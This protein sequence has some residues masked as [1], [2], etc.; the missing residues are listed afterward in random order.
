M[1]GGWRWMLGPLEE[2]QMNFQLILDYIRIN[3]KSFSFRLCNGWKRIWEGIKW[4]MLFAVDVVLIDETRNEV[5]IRLERWRQDLWFRGFKINRSKTEY[6]RCSFSRG[7]EDSREVTIGSVV[8]QRVR[9]L[10]IRARSLK[11]KG[12]LVRILIII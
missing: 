5:N 8:I 3:S 7:E 2:T 10:D 4:H 1:Y 11:R 12:I 6:L 9:S